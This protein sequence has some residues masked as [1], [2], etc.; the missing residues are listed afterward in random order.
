MS[1]GSDYEEEPAPEGEGAEGEEGGGE[2]LPDNPLVQE[3]IPEYL[4]LLS[5]IGTGLAHAYVRFDAHERDLTDIEYLKKFIHVRYLD[6]SG[7]FLSDISSINNLTHLLTLKM[8]RNNLT[9]AALD[10]LPYL[11]TANFATNKIVD[12]EGIEHPLLENLNLN[13]NQITQI[14]NFSGK[15]LCNLTTL[16][17]RG[18]KLTTTAGINIPTLK[19]LYLAAN[20]ITTI[21]GLDGLEKLQKLHIRD[22]QIS[23]LDGF[24]ENLKS[25]QYINMR[26]NSITDLKE[27]KKLTTLP[28]LRAIVMTDNPCMEEEGYRIEV[29]IILR[30]LERLDKEEY[31]TEEREEAEEISEQRK[32]E[33]MLKEGEVDEEPDQEQTED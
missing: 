12:T 24:S 15:T 8:D 30:K 3:M 16:E 13:S 21:E 4:S 17:L 10:P 9:S 29:L 14:S 11:Q 6:L 33:E 32:Q 28:M 19:N 7:N 26:G 1:D 25:L 22:N 18:N 2:K 27:L 20:Q 31:Q 5:K 23:N